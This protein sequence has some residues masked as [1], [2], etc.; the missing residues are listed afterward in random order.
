MTTKST[1][2]LFDFS[3]NAP[4]G[5][6]DT[7]L[8]TLRCA[9]E[10]VQ[11]VGALLDESFRRGI[12]LADA[13]KVKLIHP[14]YRW[15][16][17]TPL[18]LDAEKILVDHL[19]TAKIGL[20]SIDSDELVREHVPDSPYTWI[21]DP[22]DGVRHLARGLPLFTCS[23]ALRKEKETLLSV[24]YAPVTGE[25]F[26][27]LKD[28]GAYLNSWAHRLHVSDVG[29]EQALVHLE[30]P[31]RDQL[32]G[33]P[34]DFNTQCDAVSDIFSHV[35]RVRGLGLG[36]L[37][38]AYVAKGAFEAYLTLTGTTLVQDVMAGILLVEEAG[39]KTMTLDVPDVTANN[40]RV[41][42]ANQVVFDEIKK[43]LKA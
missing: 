23:V 35:K 12:I 14:Q 18:A 31:N 41:I 4:E 7:L 25:L 10:A 36:S 38:L 24:T 3:S 30:F 34:E 26:L 15:S 19:K 27:A 28:H 2:G 16:D 29:M 13:E 42:A 22:I 17:T 37:G 6:S 11:E 9:V 43:S 33:F 1:N 21:I 5:V 40:T 32:Q 20:A 39:G 8:E